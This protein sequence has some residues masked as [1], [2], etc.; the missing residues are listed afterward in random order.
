LGIVIKDMLDFRKLVVKYL[1]KVADEMDAGTSEV[2]E[3]QAIDIL[4]I[5]AHEAMSKEQAC[6]YL[7]MSRSRFDD[8]VREKKLPR[9]KK[10]V[11]FK[12]LVWYKD[13]L[14]MCRRE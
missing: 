4:R 2:T 8:L 11:G 3:S 1:R 12:E 9:G 10:R 5:V 14:D 13:E 7:N 6:N